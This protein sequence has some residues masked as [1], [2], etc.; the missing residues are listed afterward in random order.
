MPA[1]RQPL[2]S[3]SSQSDVTS[4]VARSGHVEAG[5]ENKTGLVTGSFLT[6]VQLSFACGSGG[7]T[8][9]TCPAPGFLRHRCGSGQ[10]FHSTGPPHSQLPSWPG[11]G[12][13]RSPFAI[14]KKAQCKETEVES[15]LISP[16]MTSEQLFHER[17]GLGATHHI[18]REPSSLALQVPS[19][20]SSALHT[21]LYNRLPL[22]AGAG[23]GLPLGLGVIMAF[24]RRWH[25]HHILAIFPR[26]AFDPAFCWES[27]H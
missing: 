8:K 26:I 20:H 2:L 14:L 16:L 5:P 3:K 19:C 24:C 10:P 4:C 6:A 11:V 9:T 23:R 22:G 17:R 12:G 7:C 1:T 13:L 15:P 21:S 27:S 25:T 18:T